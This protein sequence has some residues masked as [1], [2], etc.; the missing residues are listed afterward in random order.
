MSKVVE[1]R[2]TL[3]EFFKEKTLNINGK[4]IR[5][6]VGVSPGSCVKVHELGLNVV[7]KAHKHTSFVLDNHNNLVLKQSISLAEALLGFTTRIKHPN[8]TYMYIKTPKNMVINDKTKYIHKGM[9]MPLD[10]N[11]GLSKLIVIFDI[12][13]PSK[14]DSEKHEQSVKTMFGF[15]VPTIIQKST[16]KFIELNA[17]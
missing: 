12:I 14:F 17:S 3:E 11:M 8:G 4:N 6:P 2:F 10:C 1:I 13:M 7:I 15:T 5:I 9:G 16:D